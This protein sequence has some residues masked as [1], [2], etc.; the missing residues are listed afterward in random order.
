MITKI[1]LG[2][3]KTGIGCLNIVYAF[4]KLLPVRKKVTM[5]SRQSNIPSDEFRM[6]KKGINMRDKRVK[7]VFLCHTL[8]GGVNS[9]LSDKVK[10]GF[11]ML[12]QMFHIATS[13][14]VIL[15]TYCMVISI[16]KHKKELK[17]IQMWHSMGTMK[18]FGYTALDTKE[19]SK[20]ELAYAMKMHKNYDYIFASAE[21]YKDHLA[22]GFNCDIDK[23]LTMPLPRV[24]LLNSDKYGQKVRERIYKEY[25]KLKEKP[26]ILYCPTFRKE[27][28]DF[29]EALKEL[30]AAVD[31]EKYNFVVKLHPLSKAAV[32]EPAVSADGFSS[33]EMLFAADYVISDYSCIVY[34]A[35]VRHIPLY[36]YNF[37]MELYTDG[38][39]LALDYEREVPGPISEDAKKIVAAI[40]TKEYDMDA[41]K[42]FADKYVTPVRHATKDI[43]DF[44][45][46]LMNE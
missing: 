44:V 35:A 29:K 28:E 9:S 3:I 20:S 37:D 6:I 4:F 32:E 1:K 33:F 24:D 5:I 8:D 18:K 10:Y 42:K 12:T 26:L 34:E 36:F 2:I 38:R 43:V 41:L 11:H 21:S 31:Y 19:G 17:V 22:K 46:T 27:E 13:K 45:F 25:P 30:A 23:I 7:V 16:L 14:V 39:G 15:D 40:E